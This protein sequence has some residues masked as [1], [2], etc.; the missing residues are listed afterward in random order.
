M[1]ISMLTFHFLNIL[2]L[3]MNTGKTKQKN[4]YLKPLLIAMQYI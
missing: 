3:K 1:T 4:A 2:Y